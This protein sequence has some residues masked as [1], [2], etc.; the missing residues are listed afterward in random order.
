[1]VVPEILS[2]RGAL[3]ID[4]APSAGRKTP[5]R[6]KLSGRQ[7]SAEEIPS[8]RG[9]IIAIIIVIAPDFI[10]I[11]ITT[12]TI[13]STFISTITTPSHCNILG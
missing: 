4:S 8:Q 2:R 5:E 3:E 12:T 13:T 7:E 11:I 9:E 1:M 6:E 10:G